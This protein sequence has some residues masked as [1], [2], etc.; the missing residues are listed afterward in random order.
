MLEKRC[1]F[2]FGRRMKNVF[3]SFYCGDFD[4]SGG[5]AR[6]WP[7][8]RQKKQIAIPARYGDDVFDDAASL[9]CYSLY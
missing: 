1:N 8:R 7:P 9:Y 6:G 3:A 4:S 5:T 2:E